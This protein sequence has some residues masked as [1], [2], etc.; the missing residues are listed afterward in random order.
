MAGT[1][2]ATF[3]QD[4]PARFLTLEQAVRRGNAKEI[5]S[6]AH[7]FKSGA[8]TVRATFL[9]AALS[10]VEAAARTAKLNSIPALLEVVRAEH[11]AVLGELETRLAGS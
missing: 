2:L 5:E 7:A 11:L 3:T 10:D 9:A 4:C 1:L 8:G 6:A